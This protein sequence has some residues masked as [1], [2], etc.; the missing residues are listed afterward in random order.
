MEPHEFFAGLTLED[1]SV[2]A[3]GRVVIE[4]KQ[5]AEGLKA[6]VANLSPQARPERTINNY[7][8]GGCQTNT[9]KGCGTK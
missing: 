4:N 3:E 7:I 6:A 8:A 5:V 1:I 9:V 2:D